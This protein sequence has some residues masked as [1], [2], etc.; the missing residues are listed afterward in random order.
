MGISPMSLT[1]IG[2]GAGILG[3]ALGALNNKPTAAQKALNAQM[4][5]FNNYVN[6]EAK[7]EGFDATSV[8]QNLMGP[9]QRI[10]QGGPQQAGW[11]QSETNAYN[12]QAMQ[13]GAA[14]ARDLGSA[15]ASR[16]ATDT[17]AGGQA[18]SARLAAQ[19]K[20]ES[21]TSNAISSGTIQSDEAG[22]QNFFKAAGEEKEL[23][24]VFSTSNQ[25]NDVGIQ[26]NTAAQKSQAS[27][28]AAEKSSSALGIASKALSSVGGAASLP[29]MGAVKKLAMPM[30]DN[31]TFPGSSG[32][33]SGGGGSGAQWGE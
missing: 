7:T 5:D 33:T 15:A 22:R 14:E 16:A 11:S 23:P 25:A 32:V 10:V 20:A 2:M 24:G 27:L 21:D 26:S 4:Q 6:A 19:Q 13:R 31:G 3:G 1:P 29:G 12:T 30:P 17:T 9:L 28:D 18:A 8:F